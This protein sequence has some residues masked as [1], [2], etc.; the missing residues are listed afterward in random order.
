[1]QFKSFGSGS[2]GNCYYLAHGDEA[3]LIDMG[4]GT[5]YFK[6]LCRD[7]GVPLHHVKAVLVT[8]DHTDHVK[9]VAA[10]THEHNLP[11]FALPDVFQGIR[12][13]PHLVNPDPSLCRNVACGETFEVAGMQIT[14]FPVPHDSRGNV[15]YFI[16]ADGTNFCLMTD[17]G[18]FT[19]EM[20][21]YI[22]RAD[23]L[24]VEANY[25]EAMLAR[26][27]YPQFLRDRI[28]QGSGHSSNSQ[29]GSVLERSLT[30]RTRRV[31]LCHLSENNNHPE[32]ARITISQALQRAGLSPQ[33]VVLS[34][35]APS[36]LYDL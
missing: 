36:L 35:R 16:E 29:T 1:M 30:S 23:N 19:E 33:L 15:G 32:L 6:K 27:P 13:N 5:R 28:S 8:H 22:T 21:Q 34:R 7:H 2:S 4:L 11:V 20:L 24:V 31:F 14:A 25:D 26:G 18:H 10:F 17:V 9:S 12:A 3:L